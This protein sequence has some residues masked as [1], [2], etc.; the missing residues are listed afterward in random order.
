MSCEQTDEGN[1]DDLPAE[2]DNDEFK[3]RPW[4]DGSL[5]PCY[6]MHRCW[7]FGCNWDWG[8]SIKSNEAKG[9]QEVTENTEWRSGIRRLHLC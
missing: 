4:L 9:A 6:K 1:V 3:M 7:C 2:A 5:Q 8:S